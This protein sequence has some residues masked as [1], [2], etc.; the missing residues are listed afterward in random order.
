VCCRCGCGD[1][2]AATP[3]DPPCAWCCCSGSTAW[4][5]HLAALDYL[6]QGIHLR[7]CAQ[8][9][10]KQEYEREAFELFSQLLDVVKMEATRILLTVRIQTR[11]AVAEAAQAIEERSSQ[12]SNLTCTHQNVVLAASP[13][14]LATGA[15]PVLK[16]ARNDLDTNLSGSLRTLCHGQLA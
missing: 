16:I 3:F 13:T 7:G 11:E 15:E 2:S 12:V 4:R 1:R 8:K 14:D 9:N 10:P 5:E 6:R